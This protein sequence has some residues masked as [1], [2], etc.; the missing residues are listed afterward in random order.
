M[1]IAK[2]TARQQFSGAVYLWKS[3]PEVSTTRPNLVTTVDT[4]YPVANWH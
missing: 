1:G 4:F 2:Y 3:G